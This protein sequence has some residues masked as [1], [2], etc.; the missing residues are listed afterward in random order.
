MSAVIPLSFPCASL[1]TRWHGA[2]PASRAFRT[3]ANSAR[4]NPIRSA[5]LTTS[6]RS[7]ALAVYRSEEHTSELQ[8]LHTRRSSDLRSTACVTS[9]QD[10]SQLCQSEP[11]PQRPSNDEHPLDCAGCIYSRSEERRVGKE[12]RS[13][14]SPYH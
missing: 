14:W 8:S 9:L 6:T 11:D 7:T 4:V 5:L 12:C 1:Y 3:S 13:R 2:P 10:F